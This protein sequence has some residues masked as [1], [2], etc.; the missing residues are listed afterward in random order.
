[1]LLHTGERVMHQGLV[2][3]DDDGRTAAIVLTDLR[4]V[5]ELQARGRVFNVQ[6]ADILVDLPWY[7]VRNAVA[8]RKIIGQP[9]L[10]IDTFHHR[11][12]WR[13]E[14][15]EFWVR[16]IAQMRASLGHA[17]PPPPASGA[18]V[19]VNVPP[20]A[21]SQTIERQVVKVRCRHCG[22][23]GDEVVGRCPSCGAPL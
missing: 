6:S 20:A 9:V 13:A 19:I 12:L 5:I 22:Q 18:G 15:A 4:L 1:V 3:S 7:Q 11:S 17:P 23:L 14:N 10:Q 16:T 8:I 21:P 2:R